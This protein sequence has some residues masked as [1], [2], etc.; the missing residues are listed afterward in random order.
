[1]R[2]QT[3]RESGFTGTGLF[4][5]QGTYNSLIKKLFSDEMETAIW[6]IAIIAAI[7]IMIAYIITS[8]GKY[9]NIFA[10]KFL[11]KD[12]AEKDH[13]SKKENVEDNTKE[14]E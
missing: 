1:M 14:G 7:G 9:S 8:V 6:V 2:Y 11:E 3:Q 10:G 4:I 13:Y 12:K 5:N